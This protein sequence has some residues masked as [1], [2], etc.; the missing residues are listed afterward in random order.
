MEDAKVVINLKEGIVELQGP[1]D[2]VQHCLDMYGPA[3]K[4]LLGLP[5]DVAAT[6][7]KARPL[8]RER[9]AS[10]VTRSDRAGRGSYAGAVRSDL[11]AGFFD[12][13]RSTGEIKQR[14]SE[15]GVTFTDSGVRANLRRLSLAGAG[16]RAEGQ[17]RT[18]SATRL[19]L[20]DTISAMLSPGWAG[21]TSWLLYQLIP[22]P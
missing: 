17:I 18:L 11:E 9:K 2:F 21:A 3:I 22:I 4:G 6:L 7:E 8:R 1:A 5:Q 14:L 20:N 19:V 13:P 16:H 10:A 12:R 15:A